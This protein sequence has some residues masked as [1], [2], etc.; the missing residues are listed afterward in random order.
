MTLTP[1]GYYLASANGEKHLNVRVGD[2]VF[3][4]ERFRARFHRPEMVEAAL[5]GAPIPAPPRAPAAFG[6]YHALVIGNDAYTRV[7]R[8][9]TAVSDATAVGA[10][11]ARQYG[12]QVTVLEN[13]TRDDMVGVL[14]TLRRR[15]NKA[16][17]EMKADGSYRRIVEAFIASSAGTA[18]K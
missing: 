16:L 18:R 12:Y 14:D 10:V 13:A 17:A 8:L 3:G 5:R 15:L 9:R 4:I 7:P 1:E 2:D 11:L 6:R